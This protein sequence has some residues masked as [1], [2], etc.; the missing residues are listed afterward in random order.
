[1]KTQDAENKLYNA[2]KENS[3]KKDVIHSLK[4]RKIVIYGAGNYGSI[5]YN[6]LISNGISVDN[7]L[8]FIDI[9]A[10]DNSTF[11]GHDVHQPNDKKH[12][13]ECIVIVS[14]YSSLSNHE[15]IKE[16]LHHLGYED[17]ISCYEIAI[18]FHIA[19]TPSTRIVHSNFWPLNID[20]IVAGCNYWEDKV[21]LLTYINHF[22][23]YSTGKINCFS[24]ETN[25]LQYFAPPPLSNKGYRNFF[26]C[27]A[28]DGD[29]IRS[30]KEI[31]YEP[32]NIICFEPCEK[33]FNNLSRYIHSSENLSKRSVLFPCG[34]WDRTE[35]LQFNDTGGAA[36]TI[37]G[38]GDAIIQC[39]AIDD[40]IKGVQP[41]FIKMDIEGAELKAIRG[42][43][44]TIRAYQPDLAISVYHSLS[45]FWEIPALLRQFVPNYRFYLRTYGAAGF[46]T[47][48]YAV[49][50]PTREA[51]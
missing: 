21:S 38:N 12:L 33:N 40:A 50:Q 8:A 51:K 28:F 49:F 36:S 1:M 29:T 23:G 34:V 27:G 13:K 48:L 25:H 45:H 14:I 39:V 32:E 24:L 4:E 30:L 3:A 19:N 11:L 37:S 35:Q 43:E 46:E 20:K 16:H 9:T 6:L 2:I 18:S 31:G 22:T 10:T 17:I 44:E 26:D 15:K 47:I 5:I 7:I 42:A 41:T